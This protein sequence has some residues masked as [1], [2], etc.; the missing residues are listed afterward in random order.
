MVNQKVNLNYAKGELRH[1]GRFEKDT[2]TKLLS[3]LSK[4]TK[5]NKK[6]V[7]QYL[8]SRIMFTNTTPISDS[9][10]I[11]TDEILQLS[12]DNTERI[13]YMCILYLLINKHPLTPL[14]GANDE[15]FEDSFSSSTMFKFFINKRYR[16]LI[17]SVDSTGHVR[18]FN[19]NTNL[20]R[21]EQGIMR[22]G[23]LV[24]KFPYVPEAIRMSEETYIKNVKLNPNISKSEDLTIFKERVNY[25]HYNVFKKLQT[26]R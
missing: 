14:T 24:E 3:I 16:F 23:K 5:E 22:K 18:I 15:W 6:E 17:K 7:T 9:I 12:K 26:F 11:I 8:Y 1:F 2:Y 19:T 25:K 13:K 10:S 4:V 21:S 20:L